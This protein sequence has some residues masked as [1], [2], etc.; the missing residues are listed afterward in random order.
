MSRQPAPSDAYA[1][2][3]SER[4]DAI[5]KRMASLATNMASLAATMVKLATRLDAFINA[6]TANMAAL[7]SRLDALE[8]KNETPPPPATQPEQPTTVQPEQPTTVQPEQPTTMQPEQPTTV[9]PEAASELEANAPRHD[10]APVPAP[11]AENPPQRN[12]AVVRDSEEEEGR[13]EAR[14]IDSR[15]EQKNARLEGGRGSARFRLAKE[16]GHGSRNLKPPDE[17]SS[18][19]QPEPPDKIPI[20]QTQTQ[21][22]TLTPEANQSTEQLRALIAR[23]KQLDAITSEV[24]QPNEPLEVATMKSRHF[25]RMTRMCRYGQ[26]R[27]VDRNNLAQRADRIC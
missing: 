21:I 14:R 23:S 10:V 4:A 16:T 7:A 15:L 19:A 13:A 24:V 17:V 11:A 2:R 8:H 18:N 26:R 5:D 22:E 20:E 27:G 6:S 1:L 9:Q 3:M 12:H 25:K